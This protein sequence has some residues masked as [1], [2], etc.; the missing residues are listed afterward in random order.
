MSHVQL[1]QE[2]EIPVLEGLNGVSFSPG[3]ANT[4]D[5]N[6]HLI[7]IFSLE[8]NMINQ[9]C[10]LGMEKKSDTNQALE[11]WSCPPQN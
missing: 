10:L 2:W 11:D 3:S 5:S 6:N 8:H 4:L 1:E 9:L 7:M